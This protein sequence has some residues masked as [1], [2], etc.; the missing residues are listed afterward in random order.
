MQQYARLTRG[1]LLRGAA[2]LTLSARGHLRVTHHTI[3]DEIL[4][5]R[6]ALGAHQPVFGQRHAP[7]LKNFLQF[8]FRV[9]TRCL[10]VDSRNQGSEHAAHNR[11]RGVEAPIE[12]H[13]AQNRFQRIGQN[14]RTAESTALQFTLA[15]AQY[16]AQFQLDCNLCQCLL[17]YQIGTQSRQT[18]LGQAGK[19]IVEGP[20]NRAVQHGI[21]QELEP[22]VVGC[23]V[24]A[25][26]KCLRQQFRMSEGVSQGGVKL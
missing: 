12:K 26:R 13:R 7:R 23:A 22:L 17:P 25:M 3:H 24:T 20:G 5:V 6:F 15:Q 16:V 8:G 18:P 21:A 14:G 4:V 10:G 1:L 11:L 9:F 2:I 19:S